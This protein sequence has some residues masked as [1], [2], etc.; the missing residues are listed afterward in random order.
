MRQNKK[1]QVWLPLLFALVMIIGMTL[2]Y[3]LRDNTQ[4]A[5][6]FFQFSVKR[7]PIQ[8]VL[9]LIMLKYVDKVDTDTLGNSAIQDMLARLDPH[10]NFIPA[11]DLGEINDDLKGN[12]QGIGIEFQIF[13]DTVNVVSVLPGG[14]SEKAGL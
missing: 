11:V 10:S 13:K 5:R 4:T 8:E 1:L 2:G 3:K 7:S 9:D 12:F 6:S 14:P